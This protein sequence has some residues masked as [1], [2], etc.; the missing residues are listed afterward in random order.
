MARRTAAAVL[1]HTI[2]DFLNIYGLILIGLGLFF[3]VFIRASA[4]AGFC[5]LLLYYFAYPPFG[6]SLMM[7]SEG[8]LYIVNKVFIEAAYCLYSSL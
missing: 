7:Q 8:T 6:T 4:I 2:V 5:L 3:G 1:K